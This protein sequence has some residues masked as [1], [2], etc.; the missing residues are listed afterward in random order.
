MLQISVR[1]LSGFMVLFGSAVF[2]VGQFS[3]ELLIPKDTLITLERVDLF[4]CPVCIPHPNY[5]LTIAADGT[6]IL[7][8]TN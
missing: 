5:K 1:I 8:P 4:D 3:S 6:V 2:S 7:H